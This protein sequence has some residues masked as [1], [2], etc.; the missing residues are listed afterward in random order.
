ML[1]PVIRLRSSFTLAVASVI[2]CSCLSSQAQKQAPFSAAVT[3]ERVR[4]AQE[5]HI[6]RLLF[7]QSITYN[8]LADEADAA[9]DPK[10][11]FRRLMPN[12]FKLDD[13]DS[14]SLLRLSLAYQVEI[15][16]VR[17]QIDAA[18][19]AF[20]AKFPFGFRYPGMD[21]TQPAEIGELQD[22]ENA[23]TIRYRDLLRNE[24]SSEVFQKVDK[25]MH[26]TYANVGGS[27]SAEH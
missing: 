24:L 18:K 11:Y 15:A 12:R 27:Y 19:D 2:L 21:M 9:G 10:P 16:P 13:Y 7:R 17:K 14:A 23:I 20:L 6:Y 5:A 26:E 4:E 22:R 3:S 8:R 1:F 25:V